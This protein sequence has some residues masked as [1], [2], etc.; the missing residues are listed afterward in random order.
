MTSL[1]VI[2]KYINVIFQILDQE[3]EKLDPTTYLSKNLYQIILSL[4]RKIKNN[5]KWLDFIS[6]DKENQNSSNEKQIKPIQKKIT[7]YQTPQ[8]KIKDEEK[9]INT[10][11]LTERNDFSSY[12]N[13]YLNNWNR[14]KKEEIYNKN[15]LISEEF[16]SKAKNKNQ[17]ANFSVFI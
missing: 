15:E 1:S 16:L 4:S 13:P 2:Q 14:I 6:L 12:R 8:H 3:N 5:K 9:E 17:N 7:D 10:L 11:T